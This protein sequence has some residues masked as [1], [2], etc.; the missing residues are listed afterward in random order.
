MNLRS[1]VL[2]VCYMD[3]NSSVKAEF[4]D[5]RKTL[6][7]KTEGKTHLPIKKI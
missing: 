5:S 2:L 4:T 7:R 3:A 1:L 6:I